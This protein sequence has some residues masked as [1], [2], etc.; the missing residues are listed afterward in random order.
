MKIDNPVETFLGAAVIAVAIG[1]ASYAAQSGGAS[2]GPEA[3]EVVASFSSAGGVA[4]G[5]DVRIAGVK[6][7]SVSD[8][9]LDGETFRAVATLAIR[10]GVELPEDTIAL[11][12]ADG[13]LGGSYVSLQPGAS[14]DLLSPGGEI[15][16]TQG[17]ISLNGIIS[18]ALGAMGG[19]GG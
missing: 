6:V 7:G 11:I 4:P 10:A 3:Y 2:V 8:V 14:F 12:D 19:D 16:N 9:S 5:S 18:R 17:A 15:E 13:L 1:F